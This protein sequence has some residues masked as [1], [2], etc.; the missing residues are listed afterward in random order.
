M[1]APGCGTGGRSDDD[2][3]PGDPRGADSHRAGSTK[4]GQGGDAHPRADLPGE[5]SRTSQFQ[6]LQQGMQAAERGIHEVKTIQGSLETRLQ[7]LE[8]CGSDAGTTI[9]SSPQGKHAALCWED[10]TRIRQL[11]TCSKMPGGLFVTYD[12]IW[13]WTTSSYQESAAVLPSS[14][15]A[16][17][18]EKAG[19]PCGLESRRRSPKS[20]RPTSPPLGGSG[21]P[22]WF[23]AKRRSAVAGKTKFLAEEGNHLVWAPHTTSSLRQTR[24]PAPR[25]S[26]ACR[27]QVRLQVEFSRIRCAGAAPGVIFSRVHSSCKQK[28]A[29]SLRP[30]SMSLPTPSK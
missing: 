12:W 3:A 6:D 23:T 20:G 11:Q 17:V 24:T 16:P 2:Y 25:H 7:A 19:T 18:T 9:S 13:T 28:T 1:Q 29:T 10:G 15:T 5:R 22:G 30:C 26:P 4:G 14:H 8:A 21:Q 27:W